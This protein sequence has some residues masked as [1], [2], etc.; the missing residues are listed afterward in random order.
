MLSELGYLRESKTS[1]ACTV[2]ACFFHFL[3]L[4]NVP[5][6]RYHSIQLSFRI[7][8][9]CGGVQ[10]VYIPVE[11]PQSPSIKKPLLHANCS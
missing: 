8:D 5:S 9:E 10:A 6:C 11:A 2:I 7:R 1:G 4:E 3:L